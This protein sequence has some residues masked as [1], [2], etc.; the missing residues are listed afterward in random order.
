MGRGAQGADFDRGRG[1]RGAGLRPRA[2]LGYDES[3]M[4]WDAWGLG[5]PGYCARGL[6][7]ALGEVEGTHSRRLKN[8]VAVLQA[9]RRHW[10]MMHRPP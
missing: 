3:R 8:S 9:A 5:G 6:A 4:S 2:L 10:V 7:D 1:M